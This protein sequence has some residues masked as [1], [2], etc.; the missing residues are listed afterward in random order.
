MGLNP[1]TPNSDQYLISPKSNTVK[2]FTK[3]MRIK[4]MNSPRYK[5]RKC[6]SRSIENMHTD[7][8][9]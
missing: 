8:R 7:V 2:Q 3:I 6:S 1:L 9:V 4:E 5:Q